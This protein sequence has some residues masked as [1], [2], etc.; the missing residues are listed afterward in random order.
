MSAQRENALV[1]L[2]KARSLIDKLIAK[3]EGEE[4]CV[5]VMQLNLAALGLLKSAH[6]S[7]MENH[8]N[9]CFLAA[10]DTDNKKRKA[11]MVKEILEVTKLAQ[12]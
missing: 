9:T 7:L 6:L 3:I 5:N 10:V 12:R 4:Y 8:L 2:K 1:A 11:E